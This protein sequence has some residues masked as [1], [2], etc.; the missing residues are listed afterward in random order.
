MTVTVGAAAGVLKGTETATDSGEGKLLATPL[1]GEKLQTPPA[2]NPA[3]QAR[4]TVPGFRKFELA[5]SWV[6]AESEMFPAPTVT[7]GGVK[8]EGVNCTTCNGSACV[9]VALPA[10][11]DELTSSTTL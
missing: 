2:G 5:V 8:A 6:V 7:A 1:L 10:S 11:V 9:L 4:V 3:V